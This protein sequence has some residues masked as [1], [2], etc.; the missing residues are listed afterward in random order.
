M[1]RVNYAFDNRYSATLTVRVDGSSRLAPGN[2]YKAFPSAAVAWNIANES[3]LKDTGLAEQS[4][5][6]RQLRPYGQHGRKPLPD[7]GLLAVEPRQRL[8]QLRRHRRSRRGAY[9]H[10]EPQ[11]GLGIHGHHQLWPRFWLPE[12]RISGAVE[13]YQQR[14]SDLLLPDALPTASGYGSFTRNIGQTQNRGIE[15]SL[16]T[17]N[18]RSAN[19]D[20]FEWS[21]D[22][23]FTLNREKV[24]DLGLGE[25]ENGNQRSD[26]GNQR[27][28]GQPLYVILRLQERRHLAARKKP[29]LPKS[30]VLASAKSSMEDL[31][32]NGVVDA[33]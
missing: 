26:I 14:T 4:E 16:T 15:I 22:W 17:V 6:A 18:M 28:I 24:L 7:A 19:P 23:N 10:S 8:L 2:K 27:F 5:A 3:F 32:G 29:L 13:L 11:P 25:D 12:N 33:R 30:A 21:T 9:H 1:G 31:N 20:G